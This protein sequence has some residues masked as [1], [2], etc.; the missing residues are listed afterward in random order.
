[1]ISVSK[2]SLCVGLLIPPSGAS[3]G[4]GLENVR[5]LAEGYRG[6]RILGVDQTSKQALSKTLQ[7]LTTPGGSPDIVLENPPS[8]EAGPTNSGRGQSL[9]CSADSADYDS[10]LLEL[11]QHE[12]T[13]TA[14]LRRIKEHSTDRPRSSSLSSISVIQKNIETNTQASTTRERTNDIVEIESL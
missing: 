14:P 4:G 1:M 3:P 7:E 11:R 9:L 5:R 2:E 12:N 10:N 13:S 8:K 6:N